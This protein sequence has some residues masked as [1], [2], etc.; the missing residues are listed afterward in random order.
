MDEITELADRLRA[1][2]RRGEELGLEFEIEFGALTDDERDEFL[3]LQDQR[4]AH[5]EERV[6]AIEAQNRALKALLR[7]Q[8]RGLRACPSGRPSAAV[9]SASWRS[10]RR[11]A[12]CPTRWRSA[13]RTSAGPKVWPT[14]ATPPSS[15]VFTTQSA[16]FKRIIRGRG[17]RSAAAP[18]TVANTPAISLQNQ[19]TDRPKA[20]VRPIEIRIPSTASRKGSRPRRSSS[21]VR[22]RL[23]LDRAVAAS[24][25]IVAGCWSSGF[26]I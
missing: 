17:K 26:G 8:V 10:S 15:Y 12:R 24:N 21:T 14:P 18:A 6:E 25:R 16:T 19:G 1:K 22:S 4:I 23:A 2:Q 5:G 13:S 11:S 20:T 7:V 9:T 3:A